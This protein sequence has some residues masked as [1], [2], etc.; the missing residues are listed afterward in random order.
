MD[1]N[2]FQTRECASKGA[3]MTVTDPVTGADSDFKIL[4]RGNDSPEA[5][6]VMFGIEKKN[7]K[8]RGGLALA[9]KNSL[10]Y[11]VGL[12]LN[13]EG[14]KENGEEV[15]FSAEKCA[16]YYQGH[17]WL[18]EQVDAFIADRGNFLRSK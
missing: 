12:T 3:W 8:S 1:L 15:K 5:E 16:E 4:L 13:W 9:K 18:R 11:L 2:K 14:V 17:P 7:V 6:Q 10:E